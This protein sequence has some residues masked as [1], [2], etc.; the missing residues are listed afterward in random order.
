MKWRMN[1]CDLNGWACTIRC[2]AKRGWDVE[3]QLSIRRSHSQP[4]FHFV[5]LKSYIYIYATLDVRIYML[6]F[7]W[8]VCVCIC[9]IGI[10]HQNAVDKLW[11]NNLSN[12]LEH[13]D[14]IETERKTK[15]SSWF[16]H[17]IFCIYMSNTMKL[18]KRGLRGRACPTQTKL[19]ENKCKSM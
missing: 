1:V 7:I 11:Q 13:I 5:I 9:S 17:P 8:C 12:W 19:D 3:A 15:E 6:V 18:S 4:R 10:Q 16:S 14:E 2:S